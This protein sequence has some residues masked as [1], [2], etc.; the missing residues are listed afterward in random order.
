MV[1]TSPW[2]DLH[3]ISDFWC[4]ETNMVYP[5]AHLCAK[6]N[7]LELLLF[8]NFVSPGRNLYQGRTKM[9]KSVQT[10]SEFGMFSWREFYLISAG[11]CFQVDQVWKLWPQGDR[12]GEGSFAGPVW[13]FNWRRESTQR[14]IRA[15]LRRRRQPRL[16]H[17]GHGGQA[18]G[19]AA[20]SMAEC[21]RQRFR[22]GLTQGAG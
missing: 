18:A 5:L 7:K 2:P 6:E 16:D 19:G 15:S 9:G 14:T 11:F 3:P 4:R 10:C 13:G 12:S 8:S 17:R 21:Q 1:C 22:I 20:S